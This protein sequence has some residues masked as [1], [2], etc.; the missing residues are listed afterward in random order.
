MSLNRPLGV[1]VPAGVV[2]VVVLSAG[3]AQA[4]GSPYVALGDSY[5]SGTGTGSYLSDG[6]SCQRSVYAYPSLIAAGKGY[7]LDLRAC[8]GATTADVTNVQLGALG[9]GTALV[10]ITAGGNDTGF[11]DVLT[12]CAKPAW[13]GNCNA[14]MTAASASPATSCPAGCPRCSPQSAAGYR[15]L[16][17]WSPATPGS[18]TA[19]TATP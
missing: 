1:L 11:A 17:S 3:P 13:A 16:R 19:R 8:S 7:A 10:T 6:T 4:A 15:R 12:E 9:A 5:S 14:A 18:S 2:A